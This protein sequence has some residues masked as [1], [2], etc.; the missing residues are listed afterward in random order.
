MSRPAPP[1]LDTVLGKAVAI[2]DAFTCDDSLLSLAQL[3]RR[4]GL[5]K[6]TA[7]RVTTDLVGTGLLDRDGVGYRLST[8]LFAMGMRASV[9]LG[10][11][12]VATPFLEDLYEHTHETVHLGVRADLDVVYLIK[13]GGH[14]QADAPSRVG[15]RMPMHC[16]AIG[17][18]LL[19][20][21]DS[22]V[23]AAVLHRGLD[24]RGPRTIS[25][26]AVLRRQ[27]R[28]I[29]EKNIAYEHEESAVGIHCIAAPITDATGAVVAAVSVTGPT[30]RFVAERHW[31]QVRSAA[32][33]ISATLTRRA[34]LRDQD[35]SFHSPERPTTHSR[36]GSARLGS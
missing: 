3:C 9:E 27:L 12:E 28:T 5:A 7:H 29:R 30:T 24:R 32:E 19:A 22:N 10:L 20:H 2:L 31:S 14:R 17:K 6:G 25:S 35:Q 11:M 18:T 15:G 33:G 26:A 8:R 23:L 21:A 1:G 13:I 34:E 36:S 4:T 16:T